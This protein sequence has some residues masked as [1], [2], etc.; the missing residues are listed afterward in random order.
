M[1]NSAQVFLAAD[2]TKIARHIP[3]Q[4]SLFLNIGTTTEEVA[5]ALLSHKGLRV[6]TNNLNVAGIMS[7]NRRDATRIPTAHDNDVAAF[8]P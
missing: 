3:D 4:A 7:G 8:V 1:E 5:R 6:I 2:H